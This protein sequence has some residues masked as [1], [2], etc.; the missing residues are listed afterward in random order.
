M[1]RKR[2]QE[3]PV[4]ANWYATF[5]DMIT[6]LM[7]FFVL[8]FAISSVNEK[9]WEIMVKSLGTSSGAGGS[10]KSATKSPTGK[11]N[12]KVAVS[13]GKEIATVN[14]VKDFNDVY[15]YLKGYV[16]DNNLENDIS[17][18]KGDGYTFITF[19]NNILFDG[20]KDELKDNGKKIL[21]VLA[22]AIANVQNQIGSM[23]FEGHTAHVKNESDQDVYFDRVLSTNRAV[24]SLIYFQ[25][26]NVIDPDKMIATGYGEYKP[27]VPD[28]GTE[29][30]RIINRRVEINITKAGSSSLSLEQIYKEIDKSDAEK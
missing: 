18:Y 25:S 19:R 13:E 17:L 8:L 20:D 30:S 9:N 27:R 28:D 16:K 14:D 2:L 5:A 24:N 23:Y 11:A 21:D 15:Y 4:Q 7:T 22:G 12:S 10:S 26:K 6:L 1:R 3:E 29:K